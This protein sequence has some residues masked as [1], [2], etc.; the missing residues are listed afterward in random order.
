MVGVV[1]VLAVPVTVK[2]AKVYPHSEKREEYMGSDFW[3]FGVHFCK[4]RQ[5]V[6][7]FIF[8]DFDSFDTFTFPLAF[9]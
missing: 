9:V 2:I 5:T 4:C 8:S 6:L 1:G 7:L 3:V